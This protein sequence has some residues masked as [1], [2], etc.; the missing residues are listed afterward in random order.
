MHRLHL[1]GVERVRGPQRVHARAPE[2][3]V[4]VDVADARDRALVEQR[5]LH[6]RSPVRE[7]LREVPWLV[8][9]AERLAA[10]AGVDVRLDLV[11]LEQEPCA[12]APDVAV[13]DREPSSSSITARRCG[14]SASAPAPCSTDPVMRRWISSA[15]PDS[16]RTIKYL[17]RRS[18]TRRARPRARARPRPVQRARQA[19]VVDRDALEAAALEHR[20]Q[21]PANG[22]DLGQLGHRRHGSRAGSADDLEQDRTLVGRHVGRARTPRALRAR[23][24]GVSSV[25]AWTSANGSPSSTR[26]PRFAR[27]RSRP[28]G[29]RVLL[30]ASPRPEMHGRVADPDR[31]QLAR[32]NPARAPRPAA[33]PAP[34]GARTRRPSRPAPR[35]SAATRRPPSRRRPQPRRGGGLLPRRSRDRRA[36][37]AGRRR[38]ARAR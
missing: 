38:R 6:R 20:R 18:T 12:E 33:R 24:L 26:S 10:D 8:R 22:L 3:L 7:A 31:A 34:R 11:G 37:A 35:S 28:S 32:R 25:R 4:G 16:K 9:L 19:R 30:R 36:Q 2:R 17:P 15:R 14:S 1:V 23:R 13:G 5:R 27:R 29:R 21:P